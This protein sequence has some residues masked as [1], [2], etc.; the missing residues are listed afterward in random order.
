MA[1]FYPQVDW[2]MSAVLE[3][4]KIRRPNENRSS[5]RTARR[6]DRAW[7]WSCPPPD[8]AG[9]RYRKEPSL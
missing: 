6:G 7:S 9:Y 5:S 3:R 2:R 4:A 8:D 1:V